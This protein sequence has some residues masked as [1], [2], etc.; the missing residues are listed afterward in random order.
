[1]DFLIIGVT[2]LRTVSNEVQ[3]SCRI[4]HCLGSLFATRSG[5]SGEF[6]HFSTLVFGVSR[7]RGRKDGDAC[8]CKICNSLLHSHYT[9]Q[10]SKFRNNSDARG[11]LVPIVRS[12]GSED[13]RASNRQGH[14]RGRPGTARRGYVVP[15]M[16]PGC[17]RERELGIPGRRREAV[18]A[19]PRTGYSWG[20][21]VGYHRI[22]CL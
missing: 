19:Q 12:M 5:L 20:S 6:T 13:G 11:E 1:M 18:D 16:L 8:V 15:G 22:A 2:D 9:T 17:N 7:S 14:D 21:L 4:P 3:V 10:M